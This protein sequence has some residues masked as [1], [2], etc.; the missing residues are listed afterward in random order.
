MLRAPR[1]R[2]SRLPKDRCPGITHPDKMPTHAHW[3]ALSVVLIVLWGHPRPTLACP[4]PCTCYVPSEV[5]CTFRSLASVPAGISKH[6]ERINLGFNSIQA[7]SETSFAGLTKLELLMIHGNDIPSIPDGA[8]R[9]LGSLQVFKF[10]YNKL[11]V[12]T[13]QTL[14]GL[15]SLMRLHIDHNK[16]E[17]IH[18]QA[19]SGLTS[20]RLL[21]LEGNLLHQLHPG[22]FSTLTFLDYFRLSTIRHLYLA[23]NRIRT[24]P[25]GMLPNMPLLENLY[26]HG[27]PWSCDCEMRWLLEWD[28]KS[29]GT[30]KCKK[31][32]AYEGGQLCAMCSSPPKLH[33]QEIHKLKDITCLKPSIESPLRQNRSR[34]GEE[35]QEPEEDGGSQLALEGF[36]FP[37]WNISLNMTDEHGNTVN[38]VCD[39]KKPMDVYKIHLNQTDPQEIDI[40]AT[41]ALDF[42]CPMT[43]ENYEKLWKLIAYY[44]EVPVRLNQELMLS[45]DPRVT[46]QY[47]QDVDDDALYYTGVRA[48]ILAEPEWVMQPTIDLQLNRRRS[49]A[50][51]VLL[52][53]YSHYA[54]TMPTK[55]ARRSRSRSW[56]MIEPN[57]AVQRAQTVLEG[58]PC[59][60]SCNVKASESPSIFWVLPDGSVLKA[61]T[62]DENGKFS[63]LTSGW[64]KIKSTEQSDS[65]L[66]QCVAQVRDEMD[67]MVYRVLV[68]PA[69][70]QPADSHTVTIQK[71]PG[72]PVM[73]PCSALAIP[74]AQLSWI[75]PNKRI[76]DNVANT[77]HAYMLAN[78]TLSIPKVQV[79]DGGYYRCVAVNQQ[80]ADHFTVGI[81]V[82][83]KGSGR[84]SKKGRHPGG[85]TLSRVPGDVVEDE[86]GSGIGDEENTSRGGLHAKDKEV[87]IKTKDEAIAGGK[88]PKKGRRKLKPWKNSEKEP[89]TNIAEGRRVFESRRRI[90]MANKQI[91]PER[92]ADILA[93]VRGKNLP[94]GTEIPQAI[95]TTTP[96]SVSPEVT[97]ILPAVPPPSLPPARTTTSAEESSADVS[98]LGEDGQVSGAVSSARMG[99]E[100]GH[101]G[102][103]LAEPQV[104]S[105]HLEEFTD[106]GFS[107]TEDT[108]PAEVD[109]RW[110]TASTPISMP[111]ES[112][113]T[114]QTLDLVYEEP[115]G[116]STATERWPAV[117]AGSMSE[118]TSNAFE[119]PL[120]A[121][122]LAESETVPYISPDLETNPQPDEENMEELTSTPFTPTIVLWVEDS[123][124][125]EPLE[126]LTLGEPDAPSEGHPQGG[127]D[128]AL[129]VKGALSTQGS[130]LIEKGIE[131]NSE[132]LREGDM[133]ERD[134]TKSG[135]P[136]SMGTS[137]QSTTVLDS[138]PGVNGITSFK[139]PR[140]SPRGTLFDKD[141]STV[142]TVTPAEKATSPL[143]LT[144]HPSRKRH[145][146]RRRLRPHRFRNRHKPTAPTT[147]VPTE[148]FSTRPTQTPEAKAAEPAGRVPGPTAWVDSTAGAP[149]P[150]ETEKQAEAVSKGTPR[151]KHGKRPNKHRYFTSSVSSPVSASTPSPSPENKHKN[152]SAPGLETV[153]LS[154]TVSLTTGDPHGIATEED[155]VTTATKRHLPPNKFQDTIPVTYKPVWDREELK[156][157]G[158]TNVN[159]YRTG[160]S[161]PDHSIANAAS[162]LGF[163]VSTV[164]EFPEESAPPGFPATSRWNPPRV[165]R[166]GRLQTDAPVT[167]SVET[168]P[169]SPF[170]KQSE[171]LGVPSKFPPSVAASTLFQPE[172]VVAS[173]TVSSLKAEPSSSEAGTTIHAP[174]PREST[175]AE[176]RARHHI[177]TPA[178]LET[179][180]SP[181][182]AT[183]LVPS[184]QTFT[185]PTPLTSKTPPTSTVPKENVFLNYVGVPE[186]KTPPAKNEGTQHVLTPNELSTP[187]SNQ[188]KF[189][190]A[191]RQQLEKDAFV[192][193]TQN[194]LPRG[195]DG[196]HQGGRV[197]VFPQPARAPAKP[198]PPRGTARPPH[199]AT[200]G[201][202]RYF[203][204]FQPPRHLTSKPGITAYPSRVLPE[205]KPPTTPRFSSTTTPIVPAHKPKPGISTKFTDQGID[206]FNSNSKV[207]GNNNIPD[208]RD[209]AGK[210]PS[211][212][213]PHYPSGRFPFFFNR[214]LSFPQLG[215]TAR[216]QMPTS[217]AP[218][219]RERKV[220]P[221]P[222][223]RIH[224]QSIIHVDFGPPAPP[225]LPPPRATGPPSTNSQNIPVVYSTRSSIPFMASSGQPS[226][227]FHQSSSKLFS[228]G[229]PP[230]SKFWMVGEK[231]QIIT[232]SPQT[233]SVTAETDAV[234]PCEA[235]GKPTPFITWTKVSTGALMTP[236]TRVQ[237]FEVL[238]N[239]T[240]V[241]RKVQVQDRG[242]YVCTAKNLHG[243][244]RMAVLLSVTVQQPQIL[245]SHY[246][247]V[248][249]YLGDTIAMECLA[250]GTPAPQISWIFPDRRVWQ[251]VSP[252]EGRV[253][254]HENRTLSI[255]EASFSDRGVYQ[256]VASNAAGADSLAIRLHV[257]ALPPVIHQE[258]LENISLPPGLSIHIHC[259]AKAAPLPSVRWVLW[260]GTQIRPSQFINGNLF[261]FPNGTLYI[262]N[263]A[264]KDSGRYECV[265]ANLVGSARR[266]VQLTVQRAAANA[267]ITGTSPQRT[268]VRYGGTLRLDC[269]ASGDPWPRILWRLPSKRM[270]DSLFSFD[271]RIKVFA[272][273]TLVVKSVT[274][275]DAGD[276]LCVARNKVGDDFVVLKVNV[277]MRPAKIERK[278]ENDHKVFYGGDLKVDCVATGLPNPEISWSLPDGSLVNSFMQ[279]DD[280]GGRTKRYVVFNNGTLYFNEVGMREEGDYT[281]FAE[282]QVGK[283]EMR[284]RVKVVTEP[285]AIRNK[286]YSV[287]QV[288][289]GDVVTVACEAK[290]EPTPRVTWLSPTNRLIPASSDKY[291]I[292]QDGTLLIQKAQ[293]SDSGNYTC[294]VRNSAGE[295]RK[296]VWIHVN[297][298]SPTINGNPNAITTVR[299]I[300]AGGS[301]KLIDCQAEG[302]PT[303]RVLW[304]FPEG[305]VLPAPYHG[306]RITIHR[307]GT[308]DIRSLRKS[309]S[310]Q[311]TCIGR[312]EGGEARLIVQLTVLEPVEKPV[313]HDPVSEK[314]T[315]MAGHTISLNCSA[316]GTPTP[317]LLWVLPNGT[318]LQSGQQLHR[319]YHKGDGRL[320]ISGL[321]SADAGAYRCVARNSAGH[322]E[323]LVS[324]KVGVKPEVGNQYHNLVSIINGETLQLHCLPP[325][326]RPARFSWT[327]PNAM[328]LEG[329]QT[330]GRFSL[331]ENGT[332]TVR[333]AS[334]FDRG[335]YVCKADTEYGPSVMNFP[336]IVIAYPPRI[337]SEPT[338][339]IY[340][341]PG[342]TVKMNCM[343]MGI[344]KAEI[345]WDLPDKSHLTAGA[346]ARLYGNRFLHPQGSL[347]IQQATHRDAG[348]YKCTAK[349]ILGTDS[350][351]TYI[352]VY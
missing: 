66:Y 317:T 51:K 235:T 199:T 187:S 97:P 28:A 124:A 305:V 39:I 23:D 224:S 255:K 188:D 344:P 143:G 18:P 132:M 297:V 91:N 264:P 121:M 284:V 12:I 200:E 155:S 15:W 268:D 94:K 303:P 327:L 266:T 216:P 98:L 333:D 189:N 24:L 232:K 289:Y 292:Y 302:I 108:S 146:G 104:T 250:K 349:N 20:L 231:P 207:F 165:V 203:V 295:D 164:A 148:A 210:L 14:Q 275:K 41:V 9:D 215:V 96:P 340:T 270:M 72:E 177:P 126:G 324:L 40:N 307:N 286:T 252:V 263:L 13:G 247:D 277:V 139:H 115:P 119:S 84:S 242:Q 234:F 149:K 321:S 21:H 221:D 160:S 285:A 319:L 44:S 107:K 131:E 288:P 49:T 129:L 125:S 35:E 227:S 244:D 171:D 282:N 176:I 3:P 68:Q 279:S 141:T 243:V 223:N 167:S 332:L 120:G 32:K 186:A 195:P 181:F 348:F 112:S 142:T 5:H 75:L 334:V 26:L 105:T 10:S 22:T 135:S 118:T 153:L 61:P 106:H 267:R 311:L 248:T 63:I 237:R 184:V 90:N 310:V 122:S 193:T 214:T 190:P 157:Y 350:K 73:L 204:T 337:T 304:A 42:E 133:P 111:H 169:V 320:H 78:G 240:F 318:E 253:T 103:I 127:T 48:H 25:V 338:P 47:R 265:A 185:E 306:N 109:P 178:P 238:K 225:V 65:G 101:D 283:D 226:G 222:Y 69:A 218:V 329:P 136:E 54:L 38:L 87:L 308:L 16:I 34:N 147:L 257:A 36:Q 183:T 280:G 173:T 89:E 76:I 236:N 299:E 57:R 8:L 293:R 296:T 81:T 11:R 58:S 336:V 233:V 161:L 158:V 168:L 86:G 162:P 230:A 351:T 182:P 50:K 29:K 241:I 269:S 259:T 287:V 201:S 128:N 309:D 239:G 208:L 314:I 43:R 228:V 123:G 291:Q 134:P 249:V 174:G 85:K 254:L 70:T 117:G 211:S 315:A 138:T 53:Y 273:G 330:R 341:R 27:N 217:P 30:L 261:V 229:G 56:V 326:G 77:S 198:I 7:L 55:E 88:K 339:V 313:F 196:K 342:N 71:N 46:Y 154:T 92:W 152:I 80:G 191:P 328:L 220:N 323:R 150:S 180:A 251:T 31:D 258:K 316:E 246:Q 205:D 175:P 325:R 271:T 137:V 345:T 209:P 172:E 159:D 322:T 52:S 192:G 347:T 145:N 82:N 116:E 33:Q 114:L 197:Q 276:Y 60:L 278:E 17:F 67:R 294:V 74:E 346:Q 272:N 212:R 151:R 213:V 219:I 59:Q 64:L 156:H 331:W 274:D 312:N 100:S 140:E 110:A 19:F 62:E 290:G 4:H 262:R 335:T 113:P 102:L 79:S 194:S 281:C 37:P 45:K 2:V 343:A 260:D 179:T 170:L 352:H 206:R 93:R 301:R 245:A 298:Q 95:K 256:C 6:V 300:A 144:T 130:P 83:K 99:L 202:F 166:P 163:E 1:S